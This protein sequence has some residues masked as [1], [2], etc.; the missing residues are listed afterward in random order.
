MELGEVEDRHM[1]QRLGRGELGEGRDR[2]WHE[3]N[4]SHKEGM[5]VGRE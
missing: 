1:E 5:M 4:E 2:V 3:I